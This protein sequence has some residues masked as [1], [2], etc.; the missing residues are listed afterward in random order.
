MKKSMKIAVAA[1][2]AFVILGTW[3]VGFAIAEADKTSSAEASSAAVQAQTLSSGTRDR[4]CQRDR[5][6]RH[7]HL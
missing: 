5:H 7:P 4:P 1:L 2:V 6:H 3:A